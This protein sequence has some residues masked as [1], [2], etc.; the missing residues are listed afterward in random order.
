MRNLRPRFP[1]FFC[2]I[3]NHSRILATQGL[4][5]FYYPHFLPKSLKN[6]Y[7]EQLKPVADKLFW[8]RNYSTAAEYYEVIYDTVGILRIDSLL[9][10]VQCYV[11]L[12]SLDEADRY[13]QI[14]IKQKPRGAYL[15]AKYSIALR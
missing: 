9:K 7:I 4:I 12:G 3:K 10:L 6:K 8:G 13:F 5:H 1:D 2:D 14:I 11:Y 15:Y